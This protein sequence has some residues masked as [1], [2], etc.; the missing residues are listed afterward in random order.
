VIVQRRRH[1]LL[2]RSGLACDERSPRVRRQAPDQAEE[3]LHRG[4]AADH[5]P[6]DE[7]P[8][9]FLVGR[10]HGAL[11]I[12]FRLDGRQELPEPAEVDR[13]AQVIH[14]S[15]L[16]RLDGAVDRGV[17]CHQHGLALRVRLPDRAQHVQTADLR[18]LQIDDCDVGRVRVEVLER[19]GPSGAG[20][21]LEPGP[22][23]EVVEEVQ[24]AW[25]IID[26]EQDGPARTHA[27]A[28]LRVASAITWRKRSCN[29]HR[30]SA[31]SFSEFSKSSARRMA[32]MWGCSCHGRALSSEGA[33]GSR[34]RLAERH[35]AT[36]P[37]RRRL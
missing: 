20:H 30:K 12:A 26:H 32:A 8:R 16:N 4:V 31:T 34:A 29:S 28:H 9:R 27:R 10:R 33:A 36:G 15:R 7:V 11:P 3:L 21:D 37:N 2:A 23:A 22:V 18:H 24:D 14:R 1:E 13:L 25:L 6:A 35:R 17:P 5:P 19:R